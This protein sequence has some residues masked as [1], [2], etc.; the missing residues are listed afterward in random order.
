MLNKA[1]FMKKVN[2]MKKKKGFL[3]KILFF[4]LLIEN[5]VVSY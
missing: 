3:K 4:Y 5:F 1:L 2:K